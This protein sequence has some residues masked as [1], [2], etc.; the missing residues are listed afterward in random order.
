[1]S[2][3]DTFLCKDN[4]K[5]DIAI[6]AISAVFAALW[7]ISSLPSSGKNPRVLSGSVVEDLSEQEIK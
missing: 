4:L 2:L 1:M 5:R 6:T 3:C 7:I